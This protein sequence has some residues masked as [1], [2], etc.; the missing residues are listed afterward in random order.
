MTVADNSFWFNTFEEHGSSILAFLT[1]R[2]GRRELAEDLLQETFVRAMRQGD[3]MSDVRRIRSYLFTTAHR[4]VLDQ[5]RRRRPALFSEVS[6]VEEEPLTDV[7]DRA[8]PLP[9]EATDLRL[10]EDRLQ[11]ALATLR[12]DHARAF[13]LAVLQQHSYAEVARETGWTLQRVKTNVHRARKKIIETLRAV[14]DPALE[15]RP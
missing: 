10:F 14:L 9:D 7:A 8:Q 2:V 5:A 13:R 11:A 15:I 1:R 12:A 3:R 4:L 6:R